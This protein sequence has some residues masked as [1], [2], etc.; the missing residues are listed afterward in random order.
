MRAAVR[1]LSDSFEP[2]NFPSSSHALSQKRDHPQHLP[3][4]G[5]LKRVRDTPQLKAS[6]RRG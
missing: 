6:A 4:K 1:V 5:L 3:H 2:Q